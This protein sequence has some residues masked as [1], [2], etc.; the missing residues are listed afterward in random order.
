M[1]GLDHCLTENGGNLSLGQRQLLCLCRALLRK[2][3]ILVLDEA[4]AL[5][6][7]KTDSLIQQTIQHI[8]QS[9]NCTVITIAH[10][11]HSILD[12]DR[13]MV[14]ESNN[15]SNDDDG[16]SQVI[17]FAPPYELL[18]DVNSRFYAMA[19]DAGDIV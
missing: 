6:D 15:G 9:Q 8:R 19:A 10:R 12:S 5:V 11:L 1:K 17:E 18:E 14:L 2:S 4:T 3:K 16:V 13:V 7:S